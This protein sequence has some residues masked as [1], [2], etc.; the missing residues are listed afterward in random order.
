[1]P[2]VHDALPFQIDH[3]IARQHGGTD[4]SANLAWACLACNIAA[5]PTLVEPIKRAMLALIG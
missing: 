3:I 2:Q 4:E 5:W 1:M